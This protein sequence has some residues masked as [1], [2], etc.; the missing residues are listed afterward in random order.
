M[1]GFFIT[2]EG[3]EG[4]GKTLLINKLAYLLQEKNISFIKTREPGST[5]IGEK[6]RYILLKLKQKKISYFTELSLF[7]AARAQHLEEIIRPALNNGKIVLCDR[8]N[9]STIVYQGFARGLGF[10]EVKKFCNFITQGLNPDFTIYLD[11]DPEVGIKRVKKLDRLDSEKIS[12]HKKVKEGYYRLIDME[13]ER[14]F[15]IDANKSE[16]EVFEKAKKAIL[17][18]LK[19]IGFIDVIR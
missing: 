7:L 8:F 13:K 16:K 9:D 14:F 3:G 2:F 10:K 5:F 4:A 6:I 1:K 17:D 19:E 18:K 11:V 15:L 12:F